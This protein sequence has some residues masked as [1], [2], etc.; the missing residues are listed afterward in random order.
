MAFFFFFV[1]PALETT[2]FESVPEVKEKMRQLTEDAPNAL[3]CAEYIGRES[4]RKFTSSS[5]KPNC[6][7]HQSC[8]FMPPPPHVVQ[9]A[10]VKQQQQ[11]QGKR[12]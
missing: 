9:Q 6:T 2:R 10:A 8:Y 7:E 4:E 1:T 5:L 12:V 3:K 11:Q